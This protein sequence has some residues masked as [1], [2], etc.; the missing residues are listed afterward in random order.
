MEATEM[1]HQIEAGDAPLAP[2][3]TKRR[4]PAKKP[5]YI[6]TGALR[7][8]DHERELIC[9]ALAI[10]GGVLTHAAAELGINVWALKRRM[11][12]HNMKPTKEAAH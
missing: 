8:K 7:L 2:T 10:T 12:A 4:G 9:K 11:T 5:P 6:V 1:K 3:P